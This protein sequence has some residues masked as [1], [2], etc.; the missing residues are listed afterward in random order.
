MAIRFP[1]IG[2]L[3]AVCALAQPGR[4]IFESQ[5]ALCHGQTGA[6]GRGPAL[7]RPKLDR[8]PDDD[9][10]RTLIAEGRG[11]MPGAAILW[12]AKDEK[13]VREA[14]ASLPIAKAGMLE[15]SVIL[16]LEPYAGF[17]PAK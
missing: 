7:N 8:A 3:L 2:L 13:E 9:A 12:E 1:I 5:C 6:G 16:P 4:L 17:G 14:V 10:L 11:D 15:L